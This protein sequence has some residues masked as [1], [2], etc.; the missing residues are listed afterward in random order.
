MSQRFNIQYSIDTEDLKDEV[1]RLL[2]KS[3]DKINKLS[4]ISI[5]SRLSLGTLED[6]D[7]VRQQLAGIDATLKDV[8]GII[9]GF[10]SY[11]SSDNAP[12][13]QKTVEK[14]KIKSDYEVSS[15]PEY[16]F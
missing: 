7:E 3:F 10:I 1:E 11:K 15:E 16:S 4:N 6:I 9:A 12:V 2:D 8:S 13:E 14:D 5:S